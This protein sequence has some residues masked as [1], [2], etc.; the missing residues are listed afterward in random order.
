MPALCYKARFSRTTK[1]LAVL[2]H[3]LNF[4][5]LHMPQPFACSKGETDVI[6]CH[7]RFLWY[8]L[9]TTEPEFAKTF[10]SKV[11]GWGT[12]DASAPGMPYTA[13]TAGD[14]LVSGL[15]DLPEDARRMGAEPRWV[16]YIGVNDV[17]AAV[18]LIKKLGGTV[19]APP[20]DVTD[21]GRISVVADSQMATFALVKWL[22]PSN[23]QLTALD[24]PGRVGWH[25]LFAGD[26]EKAFAF[27]R[28]LFDWQKAE[29]ETDPM[30][31][32]QQFSAGGKTIGGMFTKPP[33]VALPF[34][35]YYFNVGS[36]EA[37]ARRVTDGGG[38]ILEGP[39]DV[40]GGS[41]VAR[42]A[43]PQGAMFA[44]I[45]RRKDKAIG[46]FERVASRKP[47]SARARRWSW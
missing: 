3:R 1:R 46:Y 29:T 24:R 31:T 33:M 5:R 40:P 13:F 32:Y 14:T 41:R 44:L 20:A 21:V 7:G 34:W 4:A 36:T 30:S 27:Y 45:E 6:D 28:E 11:V 22:R 19:H 17:D 47:A 8:E 35:L 16:G 9:M 26:A 2:A 10:Y 12:R 39:V 25:E 15:T 43:D 18:R 42:C 38:Q 23:Q 37:A